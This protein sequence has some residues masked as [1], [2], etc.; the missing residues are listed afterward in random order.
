MNRGERGNGEQRVMPNTTKTKNVLIIANN[1]WYRRLKYTER[2]IQQSSPDTY[3]DCRT[4][5]KYVVFP[6]TFI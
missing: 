5:A 3:S 6:Q 1:H 2:K 4:S